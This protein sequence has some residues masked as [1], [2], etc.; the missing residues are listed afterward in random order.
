MPGEL[1]VGSGKASGDV[2]PMLSTCSAGR[3]GLN[4]GGAS[5]TPLPTGSFA[6]SWGF[7]TGDV[8]ASKGSSGDTVSSTVSITGSSSGESVSSTV[9]ITGSSAASGRVSSSTV[10]ITGS[11]SGEFCSSTVS[12]TGS[13]SGDTL[14]STVSRPAG[15]AA[16]TRSRRPFGQRVEQRRHALVDRFQGPAGSSS[17]D[18][19]LVDRFFFFFFFRPAGRAAATRSRRPFP[20]PAGSSSGEHALVDRFGQR[21]EQR[22]HALV[23]RFG[24][25]VEQRRHALVDRSGHRVE[26]R[27]HALLDR[28]HDRIR[29]RIGHSRCR[30]INPLEPL[31]QRDSIRASGIL[32]RVWPFRLR[33][34]PAGG[35]WLSSLEWRVVEGTYG[36]VVVSWVDE[37]LVVPGSTVGVR[38]LG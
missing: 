6:P 27:R 20:S 29:R 7:T 8:L 23:D 34:P 16:A 30:L 1:A 24:Q 33:H 9:P 5:L 37:V 18:T 36:L 19:P 28:P 15:R 14:S 13:S 21:V 11:S 10:S 3:G 35:S 17:G 26:R 38:A 22:R 12:I 25:R 32:L 31:S 4:A 2:A